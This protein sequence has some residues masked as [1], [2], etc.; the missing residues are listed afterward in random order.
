M[1]LTGWGGVIV[2]ICQKDT[3]VSRDMMLMDGG[4][5]NNRRELRQLPHV[6][7]AVCSVY[8]HQIAIYYIVL[9]IHYTTN[10][11]LHST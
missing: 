11:C 9:R 3:S 1:T 8:I 5:E 4:T 7:F 10:I 2:I 6:A